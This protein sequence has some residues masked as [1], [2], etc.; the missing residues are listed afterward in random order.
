MIPFSAGLAASL[1]YLNAEGI[2]AAL[3]FDSAHY[4]QSTTLLHQ[5]VTG[6][7]NQF[8]D[9]ADFLSLDGPIL[10]LWGCVMYLI[11]GQAP[12]PA[13][14]QVL[15]YSQAF[16][17]AVNAA[18]LFFLCRKVAAASSTKAEEEGKTERKN[19]LLALAGS[20]LFAIAPAGVI[21]TSRYLTE[22]ITTTLILALVLVASTHMSKSNKDA[23]AGLSAALLGVF[24]ALLILSKPALLPAAAVVFVLT[25]VWQS[26]FS[27]C[28]RNLA[29]AAS[30]AAV[31]MLPQILFNLI[32]A[33]RFQILPERLAGWNI[34]LGSDIE[35]EG[36]SAIPVPPLL[37]LNYFD[38]PLSIIYG[39]FINHPIEYLSMTLRKMG[40]LFWTPWNDFG[41]SFVI[42]PDLAAGL[43]QTILMI[44]VCGIIASF[45]VNARSSS[46][47]EGD[48]RNLISLLCGLVIVAHLVFVPFESI[49][50]YAFSATPFLI[51]SAVFLMS[52]LTKPWAFL[53][54]PMVASCVA[55]AHYSLAPLLV[56]TGL[57]F[58]QS[59]QAQCAALAT[60][61]L[62]LFLTTIQFLERR[63]ASDRR[64]VVMAKLMRCLVALGVL[65]TALS[66]AFNK[67][68][69]G[70]WQ[71]RMQDSTS[72]AVRKVLVEPESRG[73]AMPVDFAAILLDG[74][75]ENLEHA[76]LKVNGISVPLKPHSIYRI[77]HPYRYQQTLVHTMQSEAEAEGKQLSDLRQWRMVKFD[78]AFLKPGWNELSL[79]A[80]DGYP[81]TIYGDYVN[82]S[83][84]R[85]HLPSLQSFALCKVQC[86]NNGRDGRPLD[87]I[88]TPANESECHV[89]SNLVRNAS[90]DLSSSPGKQ[91]GTYRMFIMTAH[92]KRASNGAECKID[93]MTFENRFVTLY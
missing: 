42:H 39:I 5:I 60:C 90:A 33:K 82:G 28:V 6:H 8:R 78:P 20:L 54:L 79:T 25:F 70:E 92:K 91:T 88:G 3:V 34:A 9:L 15:L 21:A 53:C 16:L 75:P 2:R 67:Q 32:A 38:K 35:T 24:A 37:E 18:L 81:I 19:T 55:L 30:G 71:F 65:F 4:F 31:I 93:G 84:G 10:P 13:Q 74:A 7:S 40:R 64:S 43:H 41:S 48:R 72:T 52:L 29:A 1:F 86:G 14:P 73:I 11:S 62:A 36:W 89:Q 87:I 58:Q 57:N 22:T 68:V 44:G 66:F 49:P 51:A 17:H 85:K 46:T 77:P 12:E 61:N 27:K 45:I 83:A 59:W 80:A 56:Q 63:T 23:G 26:R 47:G 50:R 76:M 69:L